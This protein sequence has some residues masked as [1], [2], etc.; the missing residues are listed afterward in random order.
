[1]FKKRPPIYSQPCGIDIPPQAIVQADGLVTIVRKPVKRATHPK[2]F[3]LENQIKA[4]VPL[5]EE[6]CKLLDSTENLLNSFDSLISQ[7][8]TDINNPENP[9]TL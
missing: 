6:N 3:S 5:K 1:M 8:E 4:G 9:E 7:T 2:V